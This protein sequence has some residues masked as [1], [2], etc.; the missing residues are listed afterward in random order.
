MKN[1]FLSKSENC[2]LAN[3]ITALEARNGNNVY[4]S[5]WNLSHSRCDEWDCFLSCHCAN[6]RK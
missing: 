5:S 2:N 1:L 6:S 4:S 3:S